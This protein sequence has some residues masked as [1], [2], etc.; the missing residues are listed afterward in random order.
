MNDVQERY[1][2]QMRLVEVGAA[3]QAQLMNTTLRCAL[4]SA[5][6]SLGGAA[7]VEREYLQRA[8]VRCIDDQH[9]QGPSFVHT[10]AFRHPACR[11][12]AA[13]AWRALKQIHTVLGLR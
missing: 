1:T 7:R 3:G 4:E 6:T 9:T 5:A 11:D 10:S 12:V 8:G 2:R 13:G